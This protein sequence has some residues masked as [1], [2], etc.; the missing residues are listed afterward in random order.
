MFPTAVC[1]SEVS[2][3]Q[4]S[5]NQFI[6]LT[7]EERVI[8]KKEVGLTDAEI[9]MTEVDILKRLISEGA[10][11]IGGGIRGFQITDKKEMIE[12][13]D[14]TRS[15][16]MIGAVGYTVGSD[17]TGYKKLYLYGN[18]EWLTFPTWYLTDKMTIGYPS[19]TKFFLPTSSGYITGHENRL[20][21]K[22]NS[23]DAWVCQTSYTPADYAYGNVGIS[24]TY[25]ISIGRPYMKGMIGQYV[26]V[27]E[28]ESGTANLIINYGHRKGGVGAPSVDVYPT[29]GLTVSP[30]VVTDVL[31]YYTQV[32]W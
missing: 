8:L 26:Y 31:P 21:D 22:V 15:D 23:F 2:N 30:S 32:S 29:I 17:R 6:N 24:A 9:D 12:T 1:A 28:K 14:L 4:S 18:F 20:C 16:I 11:K 19:T 10:K 27:D 7:P 25:D 13:Q 3:D 5:F